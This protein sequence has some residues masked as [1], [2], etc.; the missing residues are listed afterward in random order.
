M[1]RNVH[2]SKKIEM[3]IW[4]KLKLY[5]SCVGSLY[6]KFYSPCKMSIYV[7]C[8]DICVSLGSKGY[9]NR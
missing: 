4:G 3:D 5:E 2:F 7:H 8:M 1:Y 9:H 6:S